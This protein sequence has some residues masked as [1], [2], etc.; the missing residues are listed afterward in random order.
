MAQ[1]EASKTRDLPQL[2]FGLGIRHVG[3]RT[4]AILA[5]NFRTLEGL[6]AASV[7]ELDAVP[8]IGLTVAESVRDWFADAGNRALCERLRA[9]GVRSEME[10]TGTDAGGR[11]E[12]FAG[13]LFVLTG[14]LESLTRDEAAA[15]IEARGGRV[16]SSVSK[17]TDYVVAGEEAGS[18]LDK[19]QALGVR[20]LGEAEFKEMLAR[21]G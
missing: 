2:V 14:K 15:L 1:I 18:K 6:G 5:R 7:E 16:T 9:A 19:A 21:N 10:T 11:T 8:E 4:A 12:A 17:K 20:V 3:E 13:V